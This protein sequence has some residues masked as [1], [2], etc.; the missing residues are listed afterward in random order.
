MFV[1]NF[2]LINTIYI[3]EWRWFSR[4]STINEDKEGRK[5][6]KWKRDF[7]TKGRDEC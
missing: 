1:A 5:D 6:G 4:I 7:D 2:V 3:R